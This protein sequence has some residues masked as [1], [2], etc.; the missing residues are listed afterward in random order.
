MTAAITVPAWHKFML[1]IL[2]VLADGH[3]RQRRDLRVA[4]FAHMA[5]T[6][7]HPDHRPNSRPRG[8]P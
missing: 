3:T 1:P 6:E 2:Q 8:T 7:E 4:V 5:L